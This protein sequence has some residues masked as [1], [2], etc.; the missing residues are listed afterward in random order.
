MQDQNT[1]NQKLS[2]KLC[3]AALVMFGFGFGLVPLYDVMC[4]AMICLAVFN[5]CMLCYGRT[6][7]VKCAWLSSC[8]PINMSVCL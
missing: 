5:D 2:L 4:D 1:I 3:A 6:S 8:L 7:H